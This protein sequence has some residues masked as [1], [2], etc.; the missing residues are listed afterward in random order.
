MI[1]DWY[2]CFPGRSD[3]HGGLQNLGGHSALWSEPSGP[4]TKVHVREPGSFLCWRKRTPAAHSHPASSAAK[5]RQPDMDPEWFRAGL[6]LCKVVV[7]KLGCSVPSGISMAPLQ[8]TVT[9]S[10]NTLL[11]GKRLRRAR[12]QRDFVNQKV[13]IFFFSR[14][15]CVVYHR[16][17]NPRIFVVIM[18]LMLPVLLQVLSVGRMFISKINVL[19]FFLPPL[20][21]KVQWSSLRWA[22]TYDGV[23][24]M[25][26]RS[27]GKG[28]RE[29]TTT[30]SI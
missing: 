19:Y 1:L 25:S 4:G 2:L 17:L 21:S 20:S 13:N 23:C 22:T 14:S 30:R 27:L 18:L 6:A 9:W 8:N 7:K 24:L 28:R 11:N 29:S 16:L 12:K 26:D 5:W 3:L 15:H 10:K